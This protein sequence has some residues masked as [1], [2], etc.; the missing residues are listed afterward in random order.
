MNTEWMV[1]WP[2]ITDG[3][4]ARWI[5]SIPGASG[6]PSNLCYLVSHDIGLD[7]GWNTYVV[8]LHDAFNGQP[9]ETSVTDCPG[10]TPSWASSGSIKDLRFDPNE[11]VTVAQDPITAGGPF[12]QVI[13][14]IRLA[15]PDR[16]P[17]G[18]PYVLQIDLNRPASQVT[19]VNYYY[20]TN[21][22]DPTQ[23][24]ARRWSP[25]GPSGPNRVFLSFLSR[26]AAAAGGA[27]TLPQADLSFT[28]DTRGVA[29]NTYYLCAVIT[30]TP[31]TVTHCS[32]APLI[33]Q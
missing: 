29:A 15:A 14:W 23:T 10:Q 5:W 17:S 4:M 28:W 3:M 30:I 22:S 1:P 24:A 8:D 18:T 16:V 2:N 13:D 11:N 19:S 26:G 9:E 27:D 33:V 6:Q 25:P 32:A 20:T 31:N 12:H 7:I 21:R